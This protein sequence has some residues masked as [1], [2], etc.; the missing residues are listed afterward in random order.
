MKNNMAV[1]KTI[2]LKK[3][4]VMNDSTWHLIAVGLWMAIKPTLS[5]PLE[6]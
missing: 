3:Y 1:V 6:P 2:L 4:Y 5:N